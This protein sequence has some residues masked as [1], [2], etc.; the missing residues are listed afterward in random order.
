MKL[1]VKK[2]LSF[3]N[4]RNASQALLISL[5]II[6][7]FVVLWVVVWLVV[8]WLLID[9]PCNIERL[10]DAIFLL[11]QIA[12]MLLVFFILYIFNEWLCGKNAGII[13]LPFDNTTDQK[14]YSGKAISDSLIAELNRIRHIHNCLCECEDEVTLNKMNFSSQWSK[15]CPPFSNYT[16]N[17]N[18][19]NLGTVGHGQIE[20]SI[21]PLMV[22][23]RRLW[24]FGSPG[25]E[26]SGSIQK[27]GSTIRLVARM[28]HKNVDAWE[29]SRKIQGDETIT[30][31]VKDL[32]FQI[33]PSL[34]QK[35]ITAQ[36]WDAFK[37]FTKAISSYCKHKQ[38]GSLHY[39]EDAAQNCRNALSREQEY[40]SLFYLFY[41]IGI[42]YFEKKEYSKAKEAF[43]QA[44]KI[45]P[46][47][48]NPYNGIANVYFA[49]GNYEDA[50]SAYNRALKFK[51]NFAYSLR[52]IGNIHLF[53]GEYKQA[54]KNYRKAIE[55]E[56]ELY[57]PYN[58]LGIVY[59]IQK[60]YSAAIKEFKTAVDKE[61]KLSFPHTGLG[62]SYLL[63][64]DLENAV[65][66]LEIAYDLSKDERV[67]CGNLGLARIKQSRLEDARKLWLEALEIINKLPTQT[68]EDKLYQAFYS[69]LVG[70]TETGLGNMQKLLDDPQLA[71][72]IGIVDII[73]LDAKLVARSPKKPYGIKEFIRLL[74]TAIDRY[75]PDK[76]TG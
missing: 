17:E 19:A 27:Y 71:Q 65:G 37:Y 7:L 18:I 36:K 25:I 22:I 75:H 3:I 15:D 48:P 46:K 26:I 53:R 21:G 2:L 24:P 64:G 34:G 41:K 38:T 13:V 74:L 11:L 70:E 32:A 55:I 57:A 35:S 6:D 23:L 67:N 76:A 5:P 59:C 68:L 14:Q 47:N 51:Q 42:A 4:K 29:V 10:R 72:V 12:G 30:D 31:L 39:L 8:V 1:N 16:L 49:L 9:F 61:P 52:G 69:V 73:L 56:P 44:I 20:L 50:K 60:N 58:N 40:K 33:A 28:E 45:E 43:H 62:W 66:E 63:K 54:I